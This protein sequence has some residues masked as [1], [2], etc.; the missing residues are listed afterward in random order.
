M[1]GSVAVLVCIPDRHK[2]R[3]MAGVVPVLASE[4]ECDLL[5][6]EDDGT[7][8]SPVWNSVVYSVV[9]K[10]WNESLRNYSL[11]QLIWIV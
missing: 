10:V 11:E 1:G 3:Y 4:T 9:F 5:V 6:S 7:L 2:S 8:T